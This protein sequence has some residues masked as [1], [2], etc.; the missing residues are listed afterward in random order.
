MDGMLCPGV[1]W[2]GEAPSPNMEDVVRAP[3]WNEGPALHKEEVYCERGQRENNICSPVSKLVQ[4]KL[5][6][7]S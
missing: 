5:L 1:A 3:W 4:D 6:V 2:E 7:W